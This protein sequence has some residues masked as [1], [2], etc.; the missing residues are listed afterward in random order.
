MHVHVDVHVHVIRARSDPQRNKLLS[1]PVADEPTGVPSD[2]APALA[3]APAS[4]PAQ[5]P[6]VLLRVTLALVGIGLG[7]WLLLAGTAYRRQYSAT[8]AAWHRGANNFIE[9]TL[10]RQDRD[11]L[12]C[13]AD[14]AIGGVHC[15]FGAD[16][17]PHHL[18][19]GIDDPQVLR[20]YSTV[21]NELFLGAGLWNAP[22]LRG[23]LPAHR[24]TVFC[25][26]EIVGALRTV[27]LR[28][29]PAGDFAPLD[30]SVPAG[31]LRDCAIPP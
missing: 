2:L 5:N 11:N 4:P 22:A 25:D 6:D 26:Y 16:R 28:W 21:N 19:A 14:A 30:R 27:A 15:G 1:R 29:T 23:E 13:A 7:V 24:F 18:N 20:P 10:V 31:I 17:Q 9:I 12:A 8:G 3:P